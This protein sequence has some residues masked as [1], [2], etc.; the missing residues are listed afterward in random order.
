MK[1]VIMAKITPSFLDENKEQQSERKLQTETY[2]EIFK[3]LR[4]LKA[5][6]YVTVEYSDMYDNES[7]Y[8]YAIDC[9]E[10]DGYRVERSD[11]SANTMGYRGKT[12]YKALIYAK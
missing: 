2:K 12:K 9:L 6:N 10:E 4:N 8:K 11:H 5:P 7:D 1:I 3:V